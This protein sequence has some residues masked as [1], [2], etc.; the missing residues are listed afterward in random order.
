MPVSQSNLVRHPNLVLIH[1][2]KESGK[3]TLAD[4]LVA[5]FGYTRVKMAGPLKNMLRS[6]LADAG[7]DPALIE[8]YVEGSRKEVP[9]PQMSGR[10]A[11]QLMQTLGDEWRRMQHVDFWIEIAIGKVE[12]IIAAGGRVVIDDIRYLNEF[13]RFSP[14]RPFTF[15][16]TRGQKHFE[17][18]E[19]GRHLGEV[20][21]PTGIFD[22]H[23][24]NDF[25]SKEEY[26]ALAEA[27]LHA[28]ATYED[29][30]HAV[31]TQYDPAAGMFLEAA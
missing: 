10:T 22:A 24:A 3:S 12:Q 27:Y 23:I 11:R 8:D 25:D 4:R 7:I 9:I 29:R 28:R 15:C 31:R 16:V 18:V 5:E 2:L 13:S 19:P 20:P 17:P 30:L 14:Y 6:L 26:W 1:G 21:L